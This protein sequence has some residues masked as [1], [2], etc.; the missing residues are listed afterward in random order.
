MKVIKTTFSAILGLMIFLPILANAQDQT[1]R[2][3]QSY[4]FN[5]NGKISVSNINGSITVEAWDRNEIKLEAVKTAD[6]RE[7]LSMVDVKVDAKIDSFN[8]ETDYRNWN[9]DGRNNNWR[10]G[11]SIRVEFRLTVPRGAYLD[12][13]ETVNG[14]V[15][16]SNMSNYTKISAVNGGV[17]AVNL[18]GTADLSTVNGKTEAEFESLQTTDK[19]NLETVNGTVVLTLPS[20]INATVKASTVNGRINNDFSLPVKK[21]KY[22]GR[23][24]YGRIGGGGVQ[25]QLEAVNGTLSIKRK[26]DGKTQNP[27]T[28]LL[29]MDSDDQIE[30]DNDAAKE[31]AKVNREIAK[32]QADAQKEAEKGMKEAQRELS[33]LQPLI[34]DIISDTITETTEA[35][36]NIVSKEVQERIKEQSERQ[37]EQSARLRNVNF[38]G[39][40]NVS[41]KNETFSITDKSKIKIVAEDCAIAVRGWDKAEVK[42]VLTEFATGRKNSGNVKAEQ[43]GSNV[44]IAVV[45]DEGKSGDD[46]NSMRLEIFVPRKS[47][48]S[49]KTNGEIRIEGI[50]GE[51]D[52]KSSESAINVRNSDGR[53][54]V[55][56]L[57]GRIRVIG[58]QGD[59]T[60]ES[61]E[62]DVFVEGK[63]EKLYAKTV[64]GSVVL[65][66]PSET[67]ATLTADREIEMDNIDLT[68]VGNKK[69]KIGNGNAKYALS[70]IDG[71]L[72]V[73]GM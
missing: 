7:S 33:K 14:S 30:F 39:I 60:A 21:G 4:S 35:A 71:K 19:I 72:I 13:I 57:E 53:L 59:V 61:V 3:E 58:F 48:L 5:S 66:I 26:N 69:W 15:T 2:I 45:N 46:Y 43:K 11:R 44:N 51:V 56:S 62:G 9:N 40:P 31:N 42:Y 65:T 12:E 24:L 50:S 28:N 68:A 34:N 22:V 67:G 63:F 52:L 55:N 37:K 6:S 54:I 70:A 23:D 41:Q 20:D 10:N 8:V 27:A 36:N 64:E 32:I 73:R 17:R 38:A 25:I 49:I 18:R 16:V 29:K 1:E 47:D